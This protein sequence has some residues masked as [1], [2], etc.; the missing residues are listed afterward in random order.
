MGTEI[1]KLR[2]ENL[3]TMTP[4]GEYLLN[5]GEK[6]SV[7]PRLHE[8]KCDIHNYIDRPKACK[9]FPIFICENKKIRISERCPA[10]RADLFYKYISEFKGLGYDIQ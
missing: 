5:L 6:D 9:E 8:F 3:I 2:E 1:S 10:S 7:C 4:E